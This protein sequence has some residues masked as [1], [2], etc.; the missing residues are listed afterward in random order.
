MLAFLALE[1]RKGQQG[2]GLSAFAGDYRF[3]FL[4]HFAFLR[5]AWLETYR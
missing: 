3:P 1:G 2:Q 4:Y 5:L